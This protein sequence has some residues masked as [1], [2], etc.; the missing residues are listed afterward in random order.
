MTLSPGRA[1]ED[2]LALWQGLGYYSRARNL[3]RAAKAMI[4]EGEGKV[5]RSVEALRRLP[6]V[7]EYTAAAIATFAFD[8]RRAGDRREYRASPRPLAELAETGG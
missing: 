5:P 7:G 3:H 8:A 2:V 4:E 6:G 1:E